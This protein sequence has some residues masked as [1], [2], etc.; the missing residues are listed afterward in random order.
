MASLNSPLVSIPLRP[1]HSIL[2]VPNGR[3]VTSHSQTL[4]LI[5]QCTNLK[6]LKELHAT[7]LR[8][9]LFFHPYNAS[10]LF[11]VAALSSFSSLD[12]ARKVFEEISQPNLYTWNTLIRAFASSP[13]PIHSL[14][15]FIRMLY[16]SPDFPNKFTFPFVIKAAAG[17]ASLPFSQAIHGMA[18]K[19]SLGSDL[20]ILNSLIHCYASCGDLDSAYSVFVKIEEKDVV[21]WNSMIKGFVLGGCPDKALEL[22]QLMKA[23]NVRPNDVTMVGVLSA[24]AKKMDLEFGRRVCHYIERNGINVNLT[25][26]NAM[27][28]MYVKNG[29][30][31]D[32]RRLFDKME[33][34]DIFSWTTMIDGYAKRRDFDAARSVF[35]A[36]P[37]QDIS[38]WNVLI[39]A[40]EQD[41]KPKEA[42]A[43]F[44]ELQ[45]S[46][47]AKPDEVTLVSTL[48]ACAQLGAIDIGGWIHVYIKKQDIKLN[49]HLTTSLIDMYSKCGEVE[50]AL[51]IF[52]SVDRRDVFVWSAMIAG[53]AMHGRGRAA[54]D[55]FFEMQE[56]KVRPN[57]VTFTNLLCA[58]SHTGLV[59]EG[60]MFFNQMESVYGVV[61]GIKHYACM[62]DIL[63][64]A[65][66]LGEAIELV[67]K[68]P[69]DPNASVWGALL[70]ACRI[71]GNVEL[72]EMA[73]SRLLDMDPCNHGAY[74]LL[75]NIYAKTGKW[76]K[77]S[78]L[79]QHMKDF[80]IKKEPGCS[81]IE[82]DG[83]IHE[84]L[85][86]D[87]SHPLSKQIY[88]KLDEIVARL[89]STGY[90]PNASHVLQFVEEEDM[91]EKALNLHSEKLA[92][93]FGLI[94][95]GPSQPIRIVKNLRV[96][97]DCHLVAKL[98]S[99]LYN[100]DIILRDRYRFHHF[101]GG[102]CSCMD[103]W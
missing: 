90:V 1:N 76:D 44:H 16:D 56:T 88:T 95:L 97:G 25:V 93:A 18:I 72:A 103:Y 64:R 45:L 77:V 28:D 61:P 35:D 70:G 99:K 40:Y 83:V 9:G 38:A 81:S 31:E 46:K 37:R 49:C 36:M 78:G 33:E 75:S 73:C 82:V 7:I 8:S 22:F 69:I 27:L 41:G 17:V 32:A 29:S 94:S 54:I 30:L 14:L 89:K 55:L 13:E 68:M 91:K 86:G 51:D 79:R 80:G 52:Y 23:E 100:R 19:A 71:H 58:C 66:L 10:K 15:I 60:R 20:F 4:S 85:V 65:G 39:S 47:T 26:S 63:G 11:S 50:K 43:I 53:L 98:V 2:T 24:C 96:C 57:A 21:S 67:E 12:Y 59:N 34:K 48:S 102:N 3:P 101:S 6:H 92:I 87:N 84:F 42:L 5:D 74:V 62:V